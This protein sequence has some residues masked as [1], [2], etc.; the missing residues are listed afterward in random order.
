MEEII[1]VSRITSNDTQP[2]VYLPKRLEKLDL[3]KGVRVLLK[4]DRER[5]RLIIEPLPPFP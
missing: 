2:L 3:K 4:W 5:R 1:R